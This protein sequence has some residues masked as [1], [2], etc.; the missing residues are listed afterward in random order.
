MWITIHIYYSGDRDHLIRTGIKPIV[1]M[2]IRRNYATQYFWVRNSERGRN[3]RLRF[4]MD[5]PNE[6]IRIESVVKDHLG[7]FFKKNPSRRKT[8]SIIPEDDLMEND[9]IVIGDYE[10]EITRYG[11][12][13]GMVLAEKQFQLSSDVVIRALLENLEL[14][15]LKRLKLSVQLQLGLVF[16]LG[17]KKDEII[18]FFRDVH[19]TRWKKV[20]DIFYKEL[21]IYHKLP[22]RRL[23][24]EKY[25]S[26]H[27]LTISDFIEQ[28]NSR[29]ELRDYNKGDWMSD[30]LIG[31]EEIGDQLLILNKN[32][33]LVKKKSW[34]KYSNDLWPLYESLC[35]MTHNRMGT[36]NLSEGLLALTIADTLSMG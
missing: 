15:T 9:T 26:E 30:W 25:F 21:G 33:Q 32:R 36:R 35:H 28:T 27:D 1:D 19:T 18:H 5:D 31:M 14:N 7:D 29:I 24:V 17:L 16:G 10:P 22:E 13:L 34:S 4:H 23:K 2:V 6:R 11:G 8:N 20:P 3:I 12:A